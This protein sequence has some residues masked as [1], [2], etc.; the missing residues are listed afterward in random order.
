MQEPPHKKIVVL[1][2][3]A[4]PERAVSLRS[5]AAVAAGLQQAGYSVIRVD[6][7]DYDIPGLQTALESAEVVF[8]VLHGTGGED[9]SIQLLLES[10]GKISISA[11]SRAS[12]LCFDKVQYKK[13]IAE[14][15]I[16][17]P[18]GELVTT[19]SFW[20][21]EIIKQPFVLKPYDGGSS[22]DTIIVRDPENINKEQIESVLRTYDAMLLE[23]LIEGV[24]ITVGI[25]LDNALPVIEII[26]PADGEFDFDNKYNGRTQELC[27]PRHVSQELQNQ[28]RTLALQI[29]RELGI[30]DISRTDMM[31]RRTD[32]KIF[33]LETNTI[34][35]MTD[36]SLLPK[37]A[38]GAGISMPQL[39]DQLVQAALHRS[40][41]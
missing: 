39:V 33:V 17:T 2:G 11:D 6:P 7:A 22:V 9:G 18:A 24:E 32:M 4:S 27:P 3:G 13:S 5:A 31:I 41:V 19:N 28:A 29:H 14:M 16:L 36:Q 40:E 26:P 15:E 10:W 37:A 34:P 8:P 38:A 1:G 25:L 12:R 30:H 23:E 20:E 35:G 21:S